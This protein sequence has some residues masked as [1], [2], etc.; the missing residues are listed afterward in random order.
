MAQKEDVIARVFVNN[1]GFPQRLG[2]QIYIIPPLSLDDTRMTME[3]EEQIRSEDM[4][5]AALMDFFVG[6][7]HK[8]IVQNYPDM[9]VDQLRPLLNS[10]N[11][12]KIYNQI[13]DDSGLVCEPTCEVPSMEKYQEMLEK[14]RAS[15][16]Y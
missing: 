1:E 15:G 16:D 7:I 8:S 10:W 11:Y 13:L 6:V 14:Q 4:K 5:P 12:K 9:T 2:S 3:M